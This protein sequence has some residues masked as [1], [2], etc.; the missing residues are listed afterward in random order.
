MKFKKLKIKNSASIILSIL[1]FFIFAVPVCFA[2]IKIPVKIFEFSENSNVEYID[3]TV[4]NK[5]KVCRDI[6]CS[7][8]TPGIIDFN[9]GGDSPLVINEDGS[10]TGKV[11]GED[12]GWITF[13]PPYGGV[14]I[15]DTDTGLLTGTAWSE[16]SGVINFAVTGQRVIIDPATGEWNGFAWASGPHGGW[17][18]FDCRESSCLKTTAQ[19]SKNPVPFVD[20]SDTSVPEAGETKN[21]SPTFVKNF[22]ESFAKNISFGFINFYEGTAQIMIIESK[23]VGNS[24]I[25][26]ASGIA[27][28]FGK[29]ADVAIKSYDVAVDGYNTLR[30]Y[31]ISAR[32]FL[33]ARITDIGNRDAN[34]GRNYD[35]YAVSM[36][37][38]KNFSNKMADLNIKMFNK[39]GEVAYYGY[40]YLYVKMADLR[41]LLLD[42]YASLTERSY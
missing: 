20:V 11:W 2:I 35:I 42:S 1:I 27:D 37:S 6:T 7:K 17:I 36:T 25:V 9:N 31:S 18:K 32:D 30:A 14:R 29:S 38:V 21:E 12:M 8:I 10:L 34:S 24:L 23:L 5:V 3:S 40:D 39:A 4:E 26:F 15:S 13:N 16:T 22:A 41:F 28:L 19:K 33:L